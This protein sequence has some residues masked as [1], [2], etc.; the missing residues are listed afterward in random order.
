M[1]T[2]QQWHAAKELLQH[3]LTKATYTRWLAQAE[4]LPAIDGQVHIG[5]PNAKTAEWCNQRLMQPVR[6]AIIQVIGNGAVPDIVFEDASTA[7]QTPKPSGAPDDAG[8]AAFDYLPI[9]RKTGYNQL[10]HYITHFWIPYLGPAVFAT[11]NALVAGDTRNVQYRENRWTPPQEF[12]YR[13][14]AREIGA[15]SHKTI[16]GRKNECSVSRKC[17]LAGSPI[18]TTCD[19]CIH[20]VH[21]CSP[22]ADEENRCRYWSRPPACNARFRFNCLFSCGSCCVSQFNLKLFYGC[23][24]VFNL[25]EYM[26]SDVNAILGFLIL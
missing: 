12:T 24:Y 10:P 1:L 7:T 25:G 4:L 16:S 3:T 23:F 18:S 26:G 5:V 13:R 22:G 6:R 19:S 21:Q 17:R 11:W 2:H 20:T 14:L 15:K 9:W 8:I